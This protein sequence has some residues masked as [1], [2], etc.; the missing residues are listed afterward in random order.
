MARSFRITTL[1]L[2]LFVVLAAGSRTAGRQ[3]PLMPLP[4][5][6]QAPA[7]NPTTPDKVALGRLLFWDP[8]LSGP[9]DVACA[10]CHHPDFAY[11]DNRDLS[12]GVNGVG[13]GD[14][15]HFIAGNSIPLVKR[16]SQ[17]VLNTAFNG[18][19]QNGRYAASNAPMFWDLRAR[20][21]EA[22]AL[23]PVKA[24]EEM[25]GTADPADAAVAKILARVTA[26]PDY[27]A[28]FARAFGGETP[29]TAANLARAIAA[30]ERTLI[31]G[32]SP[33]DRYLR[34][35]EAA[36]S[37]AQIRGMNQFARSGCANC[38]SGTMFSDYQSHVLGIPDN[39]NL[40]QP[41]SGESGGYAFRTPSLRNVALTAPYMHNGVFRS[42]GEV[43]QFY[44]RVQ[45][46]GGRGG[47]NRTQNVNVAREDLD[48]LLRRVNVGRGRE[49]L[50]A[51]LE[52]LTDV[53]FDRTIPS[54]VP[55]GLPVGGRIRP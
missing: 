55:S 27:R 44:N 48:P 30:F 31:A 33:L 3:A 21:L 39:P 35:D 52:A 50:L 9:K 11:A 2:T 13:L 20:G 18:M 17:T 28:R 15:R 8:V 1:L 53:S 54:S 7:D 5:E 34:G 4:T 24:L 42:L 14:G 41:D 36:M 51:F 23:E 49:D 12:I 43:L 29:V 26:I 16:N 47:G 40:D 19:D 45:G 22:Q 25:R 6:V 46:R 10:T 38:H 37:P 32:N